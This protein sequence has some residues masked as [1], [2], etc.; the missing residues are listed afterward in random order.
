MATDVASLPTM[1]GAALAAVTSSRPS[2]RP[3]PQ[4]SP[5]SSAADKTYVPQFSEFSASTQLILSRINSKPGSLSAALSSASSMA[6]SMSIEKSAF[7][8]ARR[9]L[10]MNMNTSTSMLVPP[11]AKPRR[12]HDVRD[13]AH[14]RASSSAPAVDTTK[15]ARPQLPAPKPQVGRPPKQKGKAAMQGTKRKRGKDDEDPSSSLSELSDSDGE[16]KEQA[17]ATK[18]KSGRQVQKPTQF[19]PT[20]TPNSQ[21]RKH[22]GKR[23]VEQALCKVCT[24]GLS[25]PM[26]QIVFCDGCNFCWHQMCH[27]PY[28]D[29]DFVSDEGRSWFC[30]RCLAKREKALARKNKLAEHKGAS[31]A[32]KTAAQKR[33]H[34]TTNTHAQLVNILMYSLELHPELPIFPGQESGPSKRAAQR[35]ATNSPLRRGSGANFARPTNFTAVVSTPDAKT[36]EKSQT[37]R[38]GST[39]ARSQ[40]GRESSAESIIPAAWPKVG[41]GVLEGLDLD[42]D[43]L[44]D[45]NDYDS[46]SVTT[47]DQKGQKLM[48]NGV[49]V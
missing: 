9:R 2:P 45:K 23:T 32:A 15:A 24:R 14:L 36:D 42:E 22:Y 19:T 1:A 12:S 38:K 46:F 25:P 13:S 47:Y 11:A 20:D 28:I 41:K 30:S 18:T 29:D 35:S 7:E 27:D 49:A 10:V 48:E 17:P 5:A 26:N 31:W 3:S 4:P 39:E 34:L 21:K 43:D 40:A 8:D 44:Q 37:K 6:K 33:T 16:S